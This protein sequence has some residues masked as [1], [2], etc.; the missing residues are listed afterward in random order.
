LGDGKLFAAAGAWVG[1][2]GLPSVLLLAAF[3]GL[4]GALVQARLAGGL[5]PEREL[6]FGLYLAGALW[7]V[8]LYGPLGLG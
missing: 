6:P 1:W 2:Q 7:L 4:A 3:A 5:D 8:W